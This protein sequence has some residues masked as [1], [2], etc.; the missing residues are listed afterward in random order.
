MNLKNY[1]KAILN[2]LHFDVTKNLQY[3]RLTKKIIKNILKPNSVCVDIG[4]HKGEIFSLFLKYSPLGKHYAF[5]PIP[6]FYELLKTKYS[7]KNHI[8]SFALSDK[9]EDTTFQYVKNAPAFSGILRRKYTIPN[10][11]IEEIVVRTIT[12]DEIIGG[13]EKIDF[14][15][16]DVEGAEMKVLK[17]AKKVIANSKPLVLFE[18]GKGASE[19]YN[20]TANDIYEYFEDLKMSIFTLKDWINKNGPLTINKFEELYE[21]N[22]E[23][24]FVAFQN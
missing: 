4:C 6:E 9:I 11:D 19:Y 3:D 18:F 1:L 2:F 10:P 20:T 7:T 8:F 24:Y 16:I 5:E 15:K 23:Y 21:I 12:L 13:D 14:V 22:S 17:G